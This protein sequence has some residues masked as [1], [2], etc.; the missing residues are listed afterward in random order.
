[1]PTAFGCELGRSGVGD[2]E[3]NLAQPLGPHAL[4]VATDIVVRLGAALGLRPRH[5]TSPL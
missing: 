1:L 3:L 4:A 2:P 5:A